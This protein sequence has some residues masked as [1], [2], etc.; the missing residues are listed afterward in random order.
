MPPTA[1][2]NTVKAHNKV[3]LPV[4]NG[5]RRLSQPPSLSGTLFVN[6]GALE[7]GGNYSYFLI[8]REQPTEWYH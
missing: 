6:G 2:P 1:S 5:S 4:L 8:T 7:G 3:S